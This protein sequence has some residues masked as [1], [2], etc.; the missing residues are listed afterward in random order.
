V[1]FNQAKT[2]REL[3]GPFFRDYVRSVK[4]LKG[5]GD[6]D[7]FATNYLGHPAMGSV[8]GYIQIHND[9]T[10]VR[11]QISWS[12]AYWK[13]RFKALGWSTAFSTQFEL[14]LFSEATIGNVGKKPGTA[15]FVDLIVT[16]T[17]GTATI[18]LE[19]AADAYIVK[20]IERRTSNTNVV[21]LARSLL[22]PTRSVAN[23][24]R[25]QKP[26]HRDRRIEL[27]PSQRPK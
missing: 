4:G 25:F 7:D 16:P 26:W 13:S 18:V 19:D 24:L 3:K 8:S 1:R 22:N 9:P 27:P 23:L 17:L 20:R 2:R 10:G 12:K 14:G 21:V 5:W 15:G 6:G 11:Q